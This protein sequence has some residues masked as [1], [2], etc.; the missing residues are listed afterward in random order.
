M[1]LIGE[2]YQIYRFGVWRLIINVPYLGVIIFKTPS[3]SSTSI[4]F[5]NSPFSKWSETF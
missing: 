3:D 2:E 1:Y 4:L 5:P